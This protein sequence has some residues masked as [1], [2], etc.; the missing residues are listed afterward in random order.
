MVKF[1][2]L[3]RRKVIFKPNRKIQ[4]PYNY[5]H[6]VMKAIYYYISIADKQQ[7]KFLH[8][9]GYRVEEGHR[10]KLF[11]FT[12]RFSGA[13]FEKDHIEIGKNC[14]VIL[15]LS[16]VDEIINSILR[17]LL[18][19][20]QIRIGEN[21]IPLVDIKKDGYK[22]F[23][24]IMLYETLSPVVTTTKADNGYVLSLRP[25]VDKYY[26]NLAENLMKKYRLIY[27][28]DFNGK[29]YFDINDVLNMREKSHRIKGIYKIGYLYDMW[30]ETTPKMQRIIYYLG[31]GENNSTGAGCMDILMAGDSI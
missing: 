8:E 30:V 22:L 7:E 5:N 19:I 23:Q 26:I 31:L 21:D 25:Y 1:M 27:N 3:V 17:G 15:I 20:K 2:D 10:F 18:H 28:K 29:L 24:D 11:N 4:L 14:D 6:D 9:E 12:L 13:N 16:G